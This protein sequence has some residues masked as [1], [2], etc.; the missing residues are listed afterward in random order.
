MFYFLLSVVLSLVFSFLVGKFAR[1]FKILDKPDN[2]RHTHKESTPLLGGLG[3]FLSFWL[4]A[5]IWFFNSSLELNFRQ[6]GFQT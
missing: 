2:F 5:A 1:H 4:V 3:I 6:I